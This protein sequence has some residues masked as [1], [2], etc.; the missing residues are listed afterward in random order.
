P[1]MRLAPRL[2]A[3]GDSMIEA[4]DTALAAAPRCVELFAQAGEWARRHL[5][6]EPVRRDET[7]RILDEHREQEDWP[8]LAALAA[9]TA[10]ALLALDALL[11]RTV[12]VSRE[13]L[14]G[15]E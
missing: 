2:G 15:Q 4:E 3:T 7:V 12:A 6:D 11:R 9:D 13:W 5:P 1:D 8:P 10:T 14:G